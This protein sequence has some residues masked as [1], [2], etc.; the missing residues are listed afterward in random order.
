MEQKFPKR[1]CHCNKS[2]H[3]SFDGRLHDPTKHKFDCEQSLK[4]M[5]KILCKG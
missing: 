4:K 5:L 1:T 3:S 2:E